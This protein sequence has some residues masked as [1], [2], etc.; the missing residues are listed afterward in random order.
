MDGTGEIIAPCRQ[1][2]KD[3]LRLKYPALDAREEGMLPVSDLHTVSEQGSE[4]GS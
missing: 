4:R 1:I 2:N 3:N